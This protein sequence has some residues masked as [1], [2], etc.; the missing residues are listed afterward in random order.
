M[1]VRELG[2]T[3]LAVSSFGMGCNKLG[4]VS[5]RQSHR[6]AIRLVHAAVDSGIR[7]F[8]TADA[9]GAGSSETILGEA[10][11]ADS[12]VVVATKIGYRFEERSRPMQLARSL[13]SR[14]QSVAPG[15]SASVASYATQDFSAEYVNEAVRASL[16]RLRR[17]HIDVLQFHGPPPTSMTDLPEVVTELMNAGLI[18]YFGV[19]CETVESAASWSTVAGVAV[20]QL[21]FG[22]LDPVA[23]QELIPGLR[24]SGI[25]VLARG[26]LGGGILARVM[27]GQNPELD[28]LRMRRVERLRSL[29]SAND[30]DLA[31][32]AV[33]YAQYRTEVDSIL[34]GISNAGQL[35]AAA[36]FG[37]QPAPDADL[38]AA[39]RAIV[40]DVAV[41]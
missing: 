30:V 17:E 32:V 24:N 22:I 2:A 39:I 26:V 37:D 31:Q 20:V 36:R 28:P 5:A 3:D 6:S 18:R 23:A 12:D 11:A 35:A 16:R 13:L 29:A 8:D 34:I 1:N 15:R 41:S 9:Y 33:W 19:G 4:S 14:A 7:L 40:D 21:P 25:G 38:L 10:L 27:R